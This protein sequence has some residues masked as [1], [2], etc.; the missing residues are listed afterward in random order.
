M[1]LRNVTTVAVLLLAA[2]EEP[3]NGRSDTLYWYVWDAHTRPSADLIAE[4]EEILG[5][6]MV[7]DPEPT[8]GSVTIFLEDRRSGYSRSGGWSCTPYVYLETHEPPVLAH[9]LGHAFGLGHTSDD[10]NLMFDGPPAGLELTEEQID[11]IREKLWETV[12]YCR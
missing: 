4:T 5:V 1:S 7:E 12:E 2:C 10:S 3:E 9:E 11:T 6:E 8:T